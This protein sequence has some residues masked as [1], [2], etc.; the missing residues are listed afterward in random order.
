MIASNLCN[1]EDKLWI[2]QLT[3][4]GH[5]H[6]RLARLG[7]VPRGVQGPA[8]LARLRYH[9]AAGQRGNRPVADQEP[10]PGGMP[11]RRP[12][13]DH[14]ARRRDLREQARV[15]RRVGVIDAAG[16]ERKGGGPGGQC[17]AVRGAVDAVRS[18]ALSFRVVVR[19]FWPNI[20]TESSPA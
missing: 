3:F 10:Q 16:Q 15:P 1:F 6:Q 19:T 14:Q 9:C 20:C 2:G 13:A 17:A 8:A 18:L 12:F 5:G 7:R 11:A 4:T